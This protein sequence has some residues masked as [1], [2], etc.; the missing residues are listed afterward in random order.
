M[1]YD[2]AREL[3]IDPSVCALNGGEDYELLFTVKQEDY[4]KINN[5]VDI[6]IIGHITEDV[7]ERVLISKSG[8]V[9]PLKAQG[10]KAF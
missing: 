4:E 3:G 8:A 6:S 7:R 10:W 9:H 1:T 5:D 2:T